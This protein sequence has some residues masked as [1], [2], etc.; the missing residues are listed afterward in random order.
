MKRMKGKSK[1]T[2]KLTAV[3]ELRRALAERKASAIVVRHADGGETFV[4]EPTM[5][6]AM[7]DAAKS[8][9]RMRIEEIGGES[10]A[11]GID[12][13]VREWLLA[14]HP[15]ERRWMEDFSETVTFRELAER[16][17]EGEN[18]YEILDCMESQQRE[19]C[20]GRLAELTGKDYDHWYYLWLSGGDKAKYEQMVA[21][22]KK[23]VGKARRR[24]S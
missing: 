14:A 21:A 11:V 7:L 2:R 5:I 19:Y 1:A 20:F 10:E 17:E 22:W 13:I 18:F 3:K 12:E 16:M 15:E 6:R 24:R 9:L 8:E 4:E 23:A